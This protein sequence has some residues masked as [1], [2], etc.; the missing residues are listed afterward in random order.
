MATN[1]LVQPG[2]LPPQPIAALALSSKD[3]AKLLGMSERWVSEHKFKL[4]GVKV[5]G[6]LLFSLDKIKR[7]L[8]GKPVNG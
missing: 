6:A 2:P 3:V 4:G 8:E 7:V 5:G 1:P